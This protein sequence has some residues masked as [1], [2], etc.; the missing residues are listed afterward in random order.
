MLLPIYYIP[1]Q[2][3]EEQQVSFKYIEIP[4][5]IGVELHV[6]IYNYTPN[7]Y[8]KY[9]VL[10]IVLAPSQYLKIPK[11]GEVFL[12]SLFKYL[13]SQIISHLIN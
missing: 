12:F 1:L 5:F 10:I 2:Y 8:T 6:Q 13:G 9:V 3:I 4:E 7:G 11:E